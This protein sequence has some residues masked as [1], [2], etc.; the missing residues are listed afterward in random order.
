ANACTFV[1]K[2]RNTKLQQDGQSRPPDVIGQMEDKKE[3][4]YGELKGLHP[5]SEAVNTDILHL[6]TYL[7]QGFP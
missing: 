3:V 6:A 4:F 2:S 1:G 5:K 7:L